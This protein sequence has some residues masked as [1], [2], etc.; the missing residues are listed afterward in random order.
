MET[1]GS[2]KDTEV[3][4]A[5]KGNGRGRSKEEEES[6]GVA[7]FARQAGIAQRGKA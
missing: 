7:E 3:G 6:G 4:G 1:A 5:A 2:C